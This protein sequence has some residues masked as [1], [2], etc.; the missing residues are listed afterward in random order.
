MET[1]T[2]FT[3]QLI[4]QRRKDGEPASGGLL[5][6]F[7][8]ARDANGEP[9]NDKE[10]LDE[11]LSTFIA[12]TE[13]TGT[14]LTWTCYLLASHPALE[15][16]LRA[17]SLEAVGTRQPVLA[18]LEKLG[19]AKRAFLEAIRLYPPAWAMIR[20]LEQPREFQGF[21]IPE[22]SRVMV[23]PYVT[24]RHP[25][26]WDEP[27]RFDPDRFTPERSA[28]RPRFA[29]FPFGG[30]GHQCI[31]SDLAAMEA[32]LILTMIAQRYRLELDGPQRIRARPAIALAPVPVPRLK[33]FAHA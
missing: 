19:F 29:Y 4:Q 25:K 27:E 20:F 5:S 17:E 18:D 22:K 8:Q 28:G 9:M 15:E 3:R 14:A 2:G 24:H 7:M 31:G 1:L 13:T 10:L 32:Q 21:R 16:R 30:G 6:M 11:V 33:V 12:G 23:S 26:F